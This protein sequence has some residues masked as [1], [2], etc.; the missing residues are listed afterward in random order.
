M[1]TKAIFK[2]VE[3]M[4]LS[5]AEMMEAFE[6]IMETVMNTDLGN[7]PLTKMEKA[8]QPFMEEESLGSMDAEETRKFIA[9]KIKEAAEGQEQTTEGRA[10]RLILSRIL[11]R[12]KTK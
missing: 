10:K 3:R 11:I 1:I 8:L 4:N 6:E 12:M 7:N 2:V 9:E 5:E